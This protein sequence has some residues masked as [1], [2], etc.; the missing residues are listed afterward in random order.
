ML[1]FLKRTSYLIISTQ[2]KIQ[3]QEIDLISSLRQQLTFTPGPAHTS[4]VLTGNKIP[5]VN[6]TRLRLNPATY[7][8]GKVTPRNQWC[9]QIMGLGKRAQECKASAFLL[10][11]YLIKEIQFEQWVGWTPE[12]FTKFKTFGLTRCIY[13]S[14]GRPIDGRATLLVDL[15]HSKPILQKTIVH[16]YICCDIDHYPIKPYNPKPSS[17]HLC[18]D[19]CASPPLHWLRWHRTPMLWA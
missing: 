19:W 14:I 13:S 18:F 15:D 2:Q 16:I 5:S 1:S 10:S 6:I 8:F 17:W 9:L 7:L 11:F 3:F 4:D 12:E